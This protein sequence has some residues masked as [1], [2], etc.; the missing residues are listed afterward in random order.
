MACVCTFYNAGNWQLD[1]VSRSYL[2]WRCCTRI[3][4]RIQHNEY[5]HIC[6]YL[7]KGNVFEECNALF[8]ETLRI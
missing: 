2:F 3:W 7:N 1:S 8:L 6:T 5:V 4:I